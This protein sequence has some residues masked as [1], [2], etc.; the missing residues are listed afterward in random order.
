MSVASSLPVYKVEPEHLRQTRFGSTSPSVGLGE[1][2]VICSI[3]VI[4]RAA[5]PRTQKSAMSQ[6]SD[7]R[8]A[9]I[10]ILGVS[11]RCCRNG[12]LW[13]RAR[14]WGLWLAKAISNVA[15]GQNINGVRGIVFEFLAKLPNENAQ[16]RAFI[17]EARSTQRRK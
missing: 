7:M 1:I 15:V 4:D 16:I 6:L 14:L 8:V 12:S 9:T 2:L 5:N 17:S 13:S 11:L 3:L 10:S